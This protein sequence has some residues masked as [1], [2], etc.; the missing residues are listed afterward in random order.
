MLPHPSGGIVSTVLDYLTG[1]GAPFLVLPLPGA[2]TADE[3]AMAHDVAAEL[4]RT[5]V[6]MYVHGP[7]LAVIS[8]A[9]SL[10][11][12]MARAALDDPEARRASLTEILKVA[13]GCKPS[14]VPPLG[15]WLQAPMFVDTAVAGLAQVVF[16][17]GRP[18]M[19]VCMERDALFGDDPYA[20]APLTRGGDARD[21]GARMAMPGEDLP[22]RFL[23]EGSAKTDVA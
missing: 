18:S 8:A 4:V 1:L 23:E 9:G 17:A 15:M 22:V 10:D 7:A 19:L 5:E 11:V 16:A 2:E 13:P 6:L 12:D 14:A 20:V 21:D 3:T